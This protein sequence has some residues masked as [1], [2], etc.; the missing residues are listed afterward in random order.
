MLTLLHQPWQTAG[1]DQQG[2][3]TNWLFGTDGGNQN[4]RHFSRCEFFYMFARKDRGLAV[5][6]SKWFV[7]AQQFDVCWLNCP[8]WFLNENTFF[9]HLSTIQKYIASC[10]DWRSGV[11]ATL[12][13]LC[14]G[15]RVGCSPWTNPE[16]SG[17]A[18]R[19]G[20]YHTTQHAIQ[21]FV[22]STVKD[23]EGSFHLKRLIFRSV[24][25]WHVR[26]TSTVYR[27]HQ[28]GYQTWWRARIRYFICSH[29]RLHCFTDHS[30]PLKGQGKNFSFLH[31]NLALKHID[32]SGVIA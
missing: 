19:F 13:V 11:P 10:L 8:C 23:G 22:C 4:R 17:N 5:F 6:Q 2:C 16:I 12:H 24:Y 7:I 32:A 29:G 1:F 18:S 3:R 26:T 14:A 15:G 20:L 25:L 21:L 30:G 9:T 28:R 31:A 27:G